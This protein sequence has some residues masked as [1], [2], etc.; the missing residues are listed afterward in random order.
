[1]Q[2]RSLALVGTKKERSPTVDRPTLTVS[3]L[4]VGA[5]EK[6]HTPFIPGVAPLAKNVTP[7]VCFPPKTG[8]RGLSGVTS[9]P[10]RLITASA[11]LVEPALRDSRTATY[12][13][14]AA[15]KG[16]KAGRLDEMETL[17]V[18]PLSLVGDKGG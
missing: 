16:T 8:V 6:I 5:L 14:P 4:F 3:G 7:E 1:M 9:Q 17:T 12:C 15:T 10:G 18:A 11:E 13:P 2:G